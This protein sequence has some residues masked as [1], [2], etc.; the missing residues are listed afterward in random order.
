MH[1]LK[2]H[3]R[4]KTETS[5]F[6]ESVATHLAAQIRINKQYYIHIL[7]RTQIGTHTN[8]REIIKIFI[9][10]S[11]NHVIELRSGKTVHLRRTI[12]M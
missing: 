5:N 3:E 4:T 2:N 6:T 9:I 8:A 7:K 12:R 11:T 10:S 1:T